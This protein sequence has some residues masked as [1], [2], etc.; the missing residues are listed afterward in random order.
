MQAGLGL[1]GSLP[2]S[3]AL[4]GSPLF[5]QHEDEDEVEQLEDPPRTLDLAP[6]SANRPPSP[7]PD[8]P[9][10]AQGERD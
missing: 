9:D 8:C 1:V 7:S 2:P 4:V 6:F 3:P 10:T 5:D